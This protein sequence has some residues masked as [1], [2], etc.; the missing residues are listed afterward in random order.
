M[1]LF[2]LDI[3]SENPSLCH[4]A[5]SATRR[6]WLSP[7]IKKKARWVSQCKTP[8]QKKKQCNYNVYIVFISNTENSW[9]Y[10]CICVCACKSRLHHV[11][12]HWCII[13]ILRPPGQP[14][15]AWAVNQS[16]LLNSWAVGVVANLFCVLSNWSSLTWCHLICWETIWHDLCLSLFQQPLMV[17]QIE[18]P[19][20]V[21]PSTCPSETHPLPLRNVLVVA[22]PTWRDFNHVLYIHFEIDVFLPFKLMY[23]HHVPKMC[24]GNKFKR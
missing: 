23:S 14:W 16:T 6:P 15:W 2:T 20:F 11:H 18:L 3:S 13:L 9:V 7:D 12:M 17:S 10:V 21:S 8:C 1:I 19:C 24:P 5:L 22:K 4:F